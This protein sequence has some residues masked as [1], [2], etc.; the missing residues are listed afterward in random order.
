[1]LDQLEF[2]R[3]NWDIDMQ[4]VNVTDNYVFE[5]EDSVFDLY[6]HMKHILKSNLKL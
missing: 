1:M 2:H 4:K 6:F 3:F 5:M